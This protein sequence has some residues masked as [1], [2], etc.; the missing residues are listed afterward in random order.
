MNEKQSDYSEF[1]W[2]GISFAVPGNWHPAIFKH[3]KQFTRLVFDDDYTTRMEVEWIRPK[4][5][6]DIAKS[7]KRYDKAARKYNEDAQKTDI[8]KELPDEW[9]A[10]VYTMPEQVCMGSALYLSPDEDLFAHFILYFGRHDTDEHPAAILQ[11]II[12]SFRIQSK[13]PVAWKL[14]DIDM[15]VPEGFRLIN[16]DI[17][18]GKKLLGFQWEMRRLYVWY[19]GLADLILKKHPAEIWVRDLVNTFRLIKGPVFY[20]DKNGKIGFR[21]PWFQRWGRLDEWARNCRQYCVKYIHD[22]NG[23]RLIVYAY[24]YRNSSDLEKLKTLKLLPETE[25]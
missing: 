9:T 1:A 12:D 19:I 25:D 22:P 7:Q 17:Q 8:I 3:T 2:E 23:N 5:K 21:R 14:Y 10:V 18:T 4:N 13:G 15:Q 20:T 24:N 11:R 16:T 6:N